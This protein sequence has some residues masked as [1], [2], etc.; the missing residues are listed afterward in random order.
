MVAVMGSSDCPTQADFGGR[1]VY[2]IDDDADLRDSLKF[3]LSTRNASVLAFEGALDFLDNAAGLNPAPLIID[4]RMPVM[5]GLQLLKELMNRRIHWP[6]V[7]L[8]GHGEIA[9]AVQ[10]LKLGAADFL[11]KPVV[12]AEL[13]ECLNNQFMVLEKIGASSHSK[14]NALFRL[15]L[16]T[17]RES[18]VLHNLCQGLM[19]KQVARLL[20][21][22]A[23]TVEMHRFNG[24]KRLNVKSLPEVVKL[25]IVAGVL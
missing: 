4:V 5:D 15:S 19:N 7:F 13:E 24:L 9:I 22:S 3:L 8:S 6:A 16:L 25:K 21:L 14:E 17:A 10:A 1:P 12:A 11:E 23:R 2:V 18:E 20:G